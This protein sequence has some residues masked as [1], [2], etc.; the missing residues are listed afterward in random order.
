MLS[1][2]YIFAIWNIIDGMVVVVFRR[3][4]CI[5]WLLNHFYLISS[6]FIDFYLPKSVCCFFSFEFLQLV[7][8][9][10]LIKKWSFSMFVKRLSSCNQFLEKFSFK[11]IFYFFIMFFRE[12]VCVFFTKIDLFVCSW[13]D[14]YCISSSLNDW[15]FVLL[16]LYI[17]IYFV[18]WQ[19]LS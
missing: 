13:N 18:T 5:W 4:D 14:H 19:T 7:C 10:C 11:K 15:F 1:S 8:Y 17:V 16:D 6:S 9:E 3:S 2:V 12:Y